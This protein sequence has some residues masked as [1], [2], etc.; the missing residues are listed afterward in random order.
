MNICH[1]EPPELAYPSS[2]RGLY[3]NSAASSVRGVRFTFW[4]L[5]FVLAAAP[6]WVFR[7]Q[8]T[9][10][11]I[12]YLDMS[13][14]GL[15]GSDWHRLINGVWSPLYPLL[16]GM[17]RRVFP[18]PGRIEIVAAHWMNLGFFLFAFL[19][20]EF[21]LAGMFPKLEM[22]GEGGSAPPRFSGRSYLVVA[23]S[24]F[25]WASSAEIS[26]RNLRPDML[27]SGFVYIA[28]GILI[29]MHGHSARWKD[30]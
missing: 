12:S 18:I 10:D 4:A 17:V 14:G 2:P 30:Y 25:L 20:F 27:M 21:L 29:R 16:L 28:A 23:Y 13:D 6:V 24:L 22:V 5:G 9:T 8:A 1:I 3:Q 15:P 19:C 11:S 7:Y 26:V